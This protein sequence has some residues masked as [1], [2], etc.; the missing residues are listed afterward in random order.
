MLRLAEKYGDRPAAELPMLF[1]RIMQNAIS[2]YYRRQKVRSLWTTLLSSLSPGRGE[3]EDHDPLETYE[4]T[5]D[6]E[7]A[8]PPGAG[9]EQRQVLEIIEQELASYPR[10]NAKL[11]SCVTGRNWTS[12]RRPESWVAR[13]A[14]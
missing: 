5:E 8:P 12:L 9:L 7:V 1:H 14:A 6:R 3:D 2:D 10:V 4:P 13:R 11:S